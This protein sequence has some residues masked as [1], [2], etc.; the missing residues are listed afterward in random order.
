L[1]CGA[2]F[3][4]AEQFGLDVVAGELERELL[5]ALMR[6]RLRGDL[7]DRLFDGL[8]T[9]INPR[10]GSRRIFLRWRN[11]NNDEDKRYAGK[12]LCLRIRAKNCGEKS[13]ITKAARFITTSEMA[14]LVRGCSS[15]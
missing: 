2:L 9:Q 6:T 14:H 7:V 10:A 15:P 13:R 11:G 3:D 4:E 1:W 5:G 12:M 8:R